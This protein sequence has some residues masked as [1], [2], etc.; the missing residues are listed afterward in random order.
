MLFNARKLLKYFLDPG[1]KSAF[2]I[3]AYSTDLEDFR[4]TIKAKSV[5]DAVTRLLGGDHGDGQALLARYKSRMTKAR[6][7]GSA[8]INRR[9][10][11][12]RSLGKDSRILGMVPWVLEAK[13]VRHEAVRDTKGLSE[14][15]AIKLLDHMEELPRTKPVLRDRAIIRLLLDHALRRGALCKLDM[16]DFNTETGELKVLEKG[17]REKA[18]RRL[19]GSA[20][21]ALAD[22]VKIRGTHAGAI[23]INFDVLHKAKTGKR[24]SGSAIYAIL[25]ARAKGAGIKGPIRPHGLRHTSIV[26]AAAEASKRGYGLDKVR[27]H[28]GHKNVRTLEIYLDKTKEV[29][30][31]LAEAVSRRLG[32]KKGL[33][34][35]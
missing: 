26:L 32:G 21:Q 7:L 17:K 22:W 23:F 28:S 35:G 19:S 15:N 4:I 24:V 18:A 11:T 9:L 3:K 10:S 16:S 5:E 31:E 14:G 30:S 29:A 33:P 6:G 1:V 12:L 27:E 34:A 8:T 2:T 25:K 13:N 20:R